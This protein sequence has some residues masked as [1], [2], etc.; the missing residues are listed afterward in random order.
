LLFIALVISV[1]VSTLYI[2]YEIKGDFVFTKNYSL[3]KYSNIIM[4]DDI[5]VK[6]DEINNSIYVNIPSLKKETNISVDVNNIGNEDIVI[7]NYQILNVDTSLNKDN[8]IITTSLKQ[9]EVIKGGSSKKLLIKITNNNK[10]DGH[11][12]FSINTIYKES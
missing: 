6:L 8:V 7:S 9:D 12:N 4:D 11:Y 1:T 10:N 5:I 3:I 2:K